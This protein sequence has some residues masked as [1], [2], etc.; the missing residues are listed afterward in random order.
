M[1]Q[2]QIKGLEAS[3]KPLM[4]G[5]TKCSNSKNPSKCKTKFK[6]KIN[7]IDSKIRKN[8]NKIKKLIG[9]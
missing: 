9:K 8:Q 6:D 4:N 3:K 7:I 5:M 1:N 2:Y